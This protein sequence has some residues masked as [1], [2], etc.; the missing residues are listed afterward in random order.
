MTGQGRQLDRQFQRFSHSM[1]HVCL[2]GVPPEPAGWP[3]Q[4]CGG[5][6][7]CGRCGACHASLWVSRCWHATFCWT[8]D[9]VLRDARGVRPVGLRGRDGRR[10]LATATAVGAD[11][12]VA[13]ERGRR[14]R[15]R[16][17][18]SNRRDA[19]GRRA[20]REGPTGGWVS[21]AAGR[22]RRQPTGR[23]AAVAAL[24]ARNGYSLSS[25]MIASG[26]FVC[27]ERIIFNGW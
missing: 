1:W 13:R 14:A 24:R 19:P 4:M 7:G 5:G 12:T 10:G 17:G 25:A 20:H 6:A 8:T 15:S 16:A 23:H 9:V 21:T 11:G 2:H 27:M 18:A 22:G 26:D 3:S